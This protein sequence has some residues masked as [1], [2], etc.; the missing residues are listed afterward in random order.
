M[1]GIS[2]DVVIVGGE[3]LLR[4]IG[5]EGWTRSASIRESAPLHLEVSCAS[6]S[7]RKA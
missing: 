2:A 7:V 4:A 1:A 3:A 6:V 5:Y